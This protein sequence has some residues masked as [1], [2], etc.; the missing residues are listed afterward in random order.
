MASTPI[1]VEGL[2]SVANMIGLIQTVK[3]G[4][5]KVLPDPFYDLTRQV[6]GDYCTFLQ[7]QGSRRLPKASTYGAPS[8]VANKQPLSEVPVKLVHTIENQQFGQIVLQNIQALNSTGTNIVAQRAAVD[9]ITR[10]TVEFKR[11]FT[12]LRTASITGALSNGKI[13]LASDGTFLPTSTGASITID[14]QIPVASAGVGNNGTMAAILGTTLAPAGWQTA[15]TD[16]ISQLIALKTRATQLTGY[17]LKYAFYG[18]N[19][20]KY[21][22]ANTTAQALIVRSPGYNSSFLDQGDIP[23]GF[24]GLVWVPV[25]SAFFEDDNG[26]VQTF[27]GPD[28][29]VFTPE[30][31]TEWYEMIEGSYFIPASPDLIAGGNA[32]TIVQAAQTPYGMFAYAT[33]TTDPIGIKQV[34]GDTFLPVIKNPQAVYIVTV[35]F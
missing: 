23:T 30:V 33:R 25:Y 27:F 2:L 8:K 22:M 34:M 32:A 17:P 12:N 26:V 28:T 4:I 3:G 5:P 6:N 20:P 10:Q 9:E 15:S 31:T 19:I 11:R 14:F 16:I 29:I 7:V 21:L 35:N 24:Q 13:W 1:T 18:S